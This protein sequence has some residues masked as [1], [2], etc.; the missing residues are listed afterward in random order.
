M[1]STRHSRAL[2][3]GGPRRPPMLHAAPLTVKQPHRR[4]HCRDSPPQSVLPSYQAKCLPSGVLHRPSPLSRVRI[5]GQDIQS[6]CSGYSAI[7]SSHFRSFSFQPPGPHL[8][9]TLPEEYGMP[10]I[11]SQCGTWVPWRSSKP[12]ERKRPEFSH[13]SEPASLNSCPGPEIPS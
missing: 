1:G 2:H 3:D 8:V 13:S 11:T 7:R 9:N 6:T 12:L 4:T 10:F 5:A